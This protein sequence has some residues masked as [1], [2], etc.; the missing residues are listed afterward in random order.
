MQIYSVD[1]HRGKVLLWK[2]FCKYS[3]L[4]NN[5]NNSIKHKILIAAAHK[6]AF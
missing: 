2:K 4:E 1:H 3:P 5:K 6:G